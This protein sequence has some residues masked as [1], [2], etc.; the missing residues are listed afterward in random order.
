MATVSSLGIGSNLD[1]TSLLANIKSAEQAPLQ[2]LQQKQ[3]SYNAKLT[4]YGQLQSALSALQTAA[5]ALAKPELFQ[6]FTTSSSASDVLSAT[7]NVSAMSG[8]YVVNVTQLAQAQSLASA[9]VASSITALADPGSAKTTLLFDFGSISGGS[10]GSDGKY[11]GA[12][13]SP[14][15]LP[16]ATASNSI[17]IDPTKS[18]LADIRDAINGNAG[19][20]VSASIVNDGS[21]TPNR[22]VLTS[23]QTGTASSMRI[24]ASG[25]PSVSGS[26]ADP[27]IAALLSNDPASSTQLQQTMAAQNT[28]LSVNGIAVT[29]ATTSVKD[30]VQNV[31]MTVTKLGNSTLTVQNDTTSVQGAITSFVNAYNSLQGLASKLTAYDANS[32]SG[33]ALL[34]DSTLRNIQVRIRS[35]LNTEQAANSSGLNM[36]SQ[37]G[38]SFQKDSTLATDSAKLTA[39]LNTKLSGVAALFSGNSGV[40]GYGKQMATLIDNFIG[41]DGT[42][43]TATKGL[44]TTLDSLSKQYSATSERIDATV[45]RYKAQFTRL[46]VMMS[47]MNRTSS[48]LTQQFDALNN[49]SKN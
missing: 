38:V 11:T 45:A 48:Y 30:A 6:G 21:A 35:M 8:V 27:A 13:F 3:T 40:G 43:S 49:T 1:L 34:G 44:N 37:I 41:T 25:D 19:L 7:A 42:L 12:T 31:T 10:L 18:S 39:A 5:N 9:G 32:K 26:V 46:D 23:K 22:L 28:L 16:S 47:S 24:T 17:T 15:V 2:A 14:A 4:A 33:A 20:G 29:S 36:L